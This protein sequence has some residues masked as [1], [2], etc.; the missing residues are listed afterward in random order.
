MP[1]IV[2][3]EAGAYDPAELEVTE[4]SLRANVEAAREQLSAM[5]EKRREIR[6]TVPMRQVAE[7]LAETDDDHVAAVDA[8]NDAERAL[9]RFLRTDE[10]AQ[11]V[12]L[13][14]ASDAEVAEEGTE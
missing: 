9:G 11:H 12:A 3:I 13:E 2:E 5:R 7:A 8:L 10:A 6:D 14:A 1:K 4:E